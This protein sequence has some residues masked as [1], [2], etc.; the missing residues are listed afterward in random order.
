MAVRISTYKQAFN[1]IRVIPDESIR[2]VIKK[3]EL[4]GHNEKS[5]AFSIWKSQEKLK[6]FAYDKRFC[7]ILINEVHKW[8]WGKN[9]PR[10]DSYWKKKNEE[11][12]ALA[13]EKRVKAQEQ[14]ML[15]QNIGVRYGDSVKPAYVYFIQGEHGGAIKI[16]TTYDLP[17]R[18]K[19]LQTGYPDTLKCLLLIRGNKNIEEK[20]HEELKESR[21]TGEWF[22]PD[23]A[24]INK[25]NE[26]NKLGG[27]R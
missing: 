4:E 3:L 5:I 2:V 9:D 25:M 19:T 23:A 10:W 16:G 20:I 21:L 26:L 12:K 14:Q 8:S 13:L 11:A 15:K 27:K 6:T 1:L 22:S 18:L 7:N 24:V 17:K